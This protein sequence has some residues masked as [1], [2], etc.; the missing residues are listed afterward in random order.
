MD[1]DE[2]NEFDVTLDVSPMLAKMKK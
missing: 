1:V 2:F